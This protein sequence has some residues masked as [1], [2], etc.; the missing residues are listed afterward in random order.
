[1]STTMTKIVPLHDPQST[2]A[3]ADII[4]ATQDADTLRDLL[5]VWAG[6]AHTRPGLTDHDRMR[7]LE[8]AFTRF[9]RIE[10]AHE[11]DGR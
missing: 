8:S 9:L 2:A 7:V 4:L 10:A 5:K 1:M 11:G 3:A 6:S